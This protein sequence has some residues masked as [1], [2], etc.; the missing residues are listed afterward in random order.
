MP[1]S[2]DCKQQSEKE[3]S[4]EAKLITWLLQSWLPTKK[5]SLLVEHP[6][7]G[8]STP[9]CAIAAKISNGCTQQKG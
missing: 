7:A 5:L 8:K 3:T 2:S 1:Y 4:T 6:T 9:A